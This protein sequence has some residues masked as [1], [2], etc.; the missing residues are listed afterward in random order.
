MA[1]KKIVKMVCPGC[2][3]SYDEKE[4]RLMRDP[5]TGKLYTILE[6][7]RKCGG[8]RTGL[9]RQVTKLDK[10]GKIR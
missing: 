2:G 3:N 6:T 8:C 1:V 4:S 9:V 7:R 10:K 5:S